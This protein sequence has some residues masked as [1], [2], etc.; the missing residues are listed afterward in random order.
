VNDIL[1]YFPPP[2]SPRPQQVE[3]IGRIQTA[4]D[5]GKR[6]V[7]LE[8]PTGMGKSLLGM[9]VAMAV[10]GEGGRTHY[11]TTQKELQRQYQTEF[12][13]SDLI[14]VKGRNAYPCEL[15]RGKAAGDT[16]SNAPCTRDGVSILPEC[17]GSNVDTRTVTS[18]QA[19]PKDTI[20]PY[21]KQLLKAVRH[22]IVLFNFSSYLFQQR[23]HRFGH[24]DLM[25]LDE[26]HSCEGNLLSFVEL[27]MW[28]S[29]L[30]C[31]NI[32]FRRGMQTAEDVVEWIKEKTLLSRIEARIE[33]LGLTEEKAILDLSLRR[34]V[35]LQEKEDLEKLA[36]KLD[37]FLQNF[38]KTEWIVELKEDWR[39]KRKE[40]VL[41]CRPVYA[42][43][44]ADKLL[45]SKADRVLAMSA[46]IL[47]KEIWAKNLGLKLEDVEFI[48]LDSD[49][50]VENRPIILE[51]VGSMSYDKKDVTI[52]KLITW[53]R[54]TLLPRHAGERGII[55]AH[56]F[57]LA[58]AIVDGVK[59]E[60]LL[61][62]NTGQDK[63]EVMRAH[64]D[65]VD[66]VIVAPGFHEGVDLKDDLSRFQL[67]CKI[68]YPS[69]QDKVVSIR[70]KE[71]DGWFSWLTSLKLCQSVGRSVRSKTDR[72]T[73]YISDQGFDSFMWR[74]KKFLPHWFLE[75]VKKPKPKVV[76]PKLPRKP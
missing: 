71:D 68:P 52:P 27:K 58:K 64:S 38:D 26:A 70:M 16:C 44:F 75:A 21:W 5:A 29:D 22:P 56:S 31:V 33:Q 57:T 12:N 1:S 46:T 42:K 28:E 62:H 55:H 9:A 39:Y 3:A 2:Y 49:F 35:K 11:L 13:E 7:A 76:A 50:P 8:A 61:L 32:S 17:I 25:L 45:F 4:F 51:Y 60:R 47:S 20:C 48:Q 66:S 23:I 15:H 30:G 74:S 19:S 34:S 72:A 24:A 67:I 54:D 36:H 53:I 73:T 41:V 63:Q 59:S 40:Q 6:I 65:R 43:D 14:A 37:M 10:R 18:L 69:T